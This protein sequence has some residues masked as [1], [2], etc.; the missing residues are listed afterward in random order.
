MSEASSRPAGKR[1]L[2]ILLQATLFTPLAGITT[3]GAV[4][5]LVQIFS[6]DLGHIILLIVSGG[7]TFLTGYQALQFLRDLNASPALVEGE[8]AKKW[9]KGNL[10]FFFLPSFYIAVKGKIFAISKQ[11]YAQVFEA[12]LVRVLHYPNSLTVDSVQR[13]DEHERDWVAAAEF[14]E[15]AAPK[16]PSRAR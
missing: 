5:A 15:D 14:R 11:E 7:L 8:V 6:G 9:T 4:Y 2:S 12:E 16:K 1:R 10:F 13:Y 3:V